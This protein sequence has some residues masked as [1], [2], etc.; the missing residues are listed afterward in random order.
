[1]SG[2]VVKCVKDIAHVDDQILQF[3]D[4]QTLDNKV[5]FA[6]KKQFVVSSKG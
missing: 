3:V 6:R 1:M 2:S 4:T 5:G